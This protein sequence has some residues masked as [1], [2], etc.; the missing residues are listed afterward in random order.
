MIQ[1]KITGFKNQTV[2]LETQNQALAFLTNLKQEHTAFLSPLIKGIMYNAGLRNST[3]ETRMSDELKSYTK[4]LRAITAKHP[5][6]VE[7]A[8]FDADMDGLI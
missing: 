7:I 1:I 6:K 3:D 4:Q 8:E 2:E 5:L